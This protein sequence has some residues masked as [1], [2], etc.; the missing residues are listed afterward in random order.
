M[1]K[2]LIL[3]HSFVCNVEIFIGSN[4]PQYNYT[5]KFDPK[6]VIIQFSGKPSATVESLKAC[7]LA[8]IKY[9]EPEL[10]I[11]DIGHK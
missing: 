3:G 1:L 6:E 4:L 8:D 5:L 11:L 2:C 10:V 7:Q 9:F